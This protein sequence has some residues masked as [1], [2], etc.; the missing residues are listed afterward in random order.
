MLNATSAGGLAHRL[1]RTLQSSGYAKARA[2]DAQ[3][4]GTYTVT[5]VEYKH[6]DRAAAQ[7]VAHDLRVTRVQTMT[8]DLSALAVST[9]GSRP[10]PA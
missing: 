2:L 6:G 3:P 1:L 8:A 4:P 10:P 5:L 7:A 9:S